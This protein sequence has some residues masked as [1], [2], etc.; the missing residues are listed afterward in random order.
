MK[1]AFLT[2]LSIIKKAENSRF[3]YGIINVLTHHITQ[4]AFR[5]L[6]SLHSEYW[7]MVIDI[8][9]SLPCIFTELLT[10]NRMRFC[11]FML[12]TATRLYWKKI[13]EKYGS[14]PHVC[15]SIVRSLDSYLRMHTV[16]INW[17]QCG[18][19]VW[20]HHYISETALLPHFSLF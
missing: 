3:D 16:E 11:L 5:F 14:R 17:I 7:T 15:K 1:R 13:N 10:P 8:L 20:K 18:T 12:V 6:D 9:C 2:R 19:R 4:Y